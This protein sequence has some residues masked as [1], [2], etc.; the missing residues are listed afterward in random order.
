MCS[1]EFDINNKLK[2]TPWVN[3]ILK[4]Y[5]KNVFKLLFKDKNHFYMKV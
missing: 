5:L 4:C 2:L 1:K 3:A